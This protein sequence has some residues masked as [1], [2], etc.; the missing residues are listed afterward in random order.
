MYCSQFLCP[1]GLI[2]QKPRIAAYRIQRHVFRNSEYPKNSM[3]SIN[4]E[5]SWFRVS[6]PIAGITG[7]I[8]GRL[9]EQCGVDDLKL[10]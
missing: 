5:A 3:S 9:T 1:L 8:L 6:L 2:R 10:W 4:L 7:D